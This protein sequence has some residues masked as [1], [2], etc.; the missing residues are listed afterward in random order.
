[1]NGNKTNIELGGSPEEVPTLEPDADCNA[2][3]TSGAGEFEGYC[4]NPAGMGTDH[5]GSG[6]CVEC[7]GSSPGPQTETGK[8]IAAR[9]NER[10]GMTA[11]PF[12][13]HDSLEREEE[14]EFVLRVSQAIENR[15]RENTGEVDFLDEV[16]ARR[17]AVMIHIVAKASEYF[18]QE[19][20]FERITTPDGTIEVENRMLD[21]IRQYNK[22]LV[23]IL[24]DIGAAK[25][26]GSELDALA[27]WRQDLE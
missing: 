6:R 9:N 21:H 10:H 23:R 16:L 13:Y 5:E 3:R 22:D 4:D 25:D 2:K 1:M 24:D 15:I 7:A 19:E 26:T 14:T 8:L 18:T 12:K 17:A 20:L 27:V 11:D